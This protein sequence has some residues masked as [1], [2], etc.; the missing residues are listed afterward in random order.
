MLT[1]Q[2][3]PPLEWLQEKWQMFVAL[4]T[5]TGIVLHLVMVF[6]HS[7]W[8]NLPLYFLIVMGGLPVFFQ[9]VIKLLKGN[10]QRFP[11]HRT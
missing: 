6:L 9:I 1:S 8:A 7:G 2:S 3:H 11:I 4:S 5:L 10:K